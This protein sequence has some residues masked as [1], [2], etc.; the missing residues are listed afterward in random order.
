MI[1]TI[2]MVFKASMYALV[3][4]ATK[5]PP[6]CIM[7]SI[8]HNREALVNDALLTS[9]QLCINYDY[10]LDIKSSI[11]TTPSK[12]IL[13]SRPLAPFEIV[14]EWYCHYSTQRSEWCD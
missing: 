10:L 8:T 13:F 12:Q 4:Y 7:A 2:S 9:N 3:L 14:C 5:C 11:L 6:H 1:F